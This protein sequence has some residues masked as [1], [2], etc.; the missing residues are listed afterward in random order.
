MPLAS[1]SLISFDFNSSLVKLPIHNSTLLTMDYNSGMLVCGFF[2]GTFQ[3][4]NLEHSRTP[5]VH[6]PT[7]HFGPIKSIS[8]NNN[9]KIASLGQDGSI[10]SVNLNDLES[11]GTLRPVLLQR[12]CLPGSLIKI[13]QDDH[14]IS[15]E[16]ISD[17]RACNLD[18][19]EEDNRSATLLRP[20]GM[21]GKSTAFVFEGG[22]F[23]GKMLVGSDEGQLWIVLDNSKRYK[24]NTLLFGWKGRECSRLEESTGGMQVTGVDFVN[25]RVLYALSTG[26][27]HCFSLSKEPN[28]LLL[29]DKR[30]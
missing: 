17:L 2:D 5:L 11:C 28:Y 24:K 20:A 15:C 29:S 12:G 14:V 26:I 13:L 10:F 18:R 7:F 19:Y 9:W 22:A 23:N 27:V 8:I 30:K 1:E 3:I 6:L 16:A 25:D 4:W 21:E